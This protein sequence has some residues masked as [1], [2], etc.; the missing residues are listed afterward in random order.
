MTLSTPAGPR[1]G[2]PREELDTPALLLDL[3]RFDRNAAR[4]AGAIRE[5]GVAWRPHSKAHKSPFLAARQIELGA[6]GVTCA[7]VVEAEA[8]V[9]MAMAE[10]CWW[11]AGW[12]AAQVRPGGPVAGARRSHRL[13]RQLVPRGVAAAAVRPPA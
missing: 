2:L 8:Q 13:Y 9:P 5:G 10:A 4:L 1:P 7:K 6:I 12:A 11:P 3:D